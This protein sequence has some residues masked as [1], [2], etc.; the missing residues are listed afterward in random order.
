MIEAMWVSDMSL[1]RIICPLRTNRRFFSAHHTC[2]EKHTCIELSNLCSILLIFFFSYF[3]FV[4]KEHHLSSHVHSG[5]RRSVCC[6]H[7]ECRCGKLTYFTLI[8]ITDYILNVI[9]SC[10][11]YLETL[12][13]YWKVLKHSKNTTESF[14]VTW[15]QFCILSVWTDCTLFH[16]LHWW[17]LVIRLRRP[18]GL[19]VNP[20]CLPVCHIPAPVTWSSHPTHRVQEL[21]YGEPNQRNVS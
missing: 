20:S 11:Y 9:L 2:I 21:L 1:C 12:D 18:W 6:K 7:R 16:C 10:I 3:L 15:M 13:V 17:S 5:W 19:Q 8:T 4:G 14:I